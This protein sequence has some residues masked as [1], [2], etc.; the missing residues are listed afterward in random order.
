MNLDK[1]TLAVIFS[2][3]SAFTALF[4]VLVGPWLQFRA[5]RRT[6][7]SGYR[8]QWIDSLRNEFAKFQAGVAMFGTSFSESGDVKRT[9]E[10]SN[11]INL[12]LNHDEPLHREF[13]QLIEAILKYGTATLDKDNSKKMNEFQKKATVVCRKIL[14]EE[15]VRVKE[16]KQL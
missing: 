8:Q 3:L 14:K 13:Y 2:I 5:S 1:E 6:I 15:W 9:V 12:M 7:V 4:A 10:S 11:R 16:M